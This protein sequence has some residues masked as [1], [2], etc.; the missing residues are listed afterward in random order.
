M[1]SQNAGAATKLKVLSRVDELLEL[2]HR[3]GSLGNFTD[4][5]A[6]AIYKLLSRHTRE[7]PYTRAYRELRERKTSRRGSNS[8]RL[9]RRRSVRP[10]A[11]RIRAF[12]GCSD[13]EPAGRC[14]SE[15]S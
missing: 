8:P 14:P 6:E 12:S 11:S 13:P 7:A 15:L 5:L 4:Y 2:T 10:K 1:D 3:S 9:Q